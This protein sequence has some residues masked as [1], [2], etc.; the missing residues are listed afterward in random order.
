M[1]TIELDGATYVLVPK[2]AWAKLARG[3]VRMP[4]LPPADEAGN[5]D[6]IAFARVSIARTLI[7]DRVAAGLSQAELARRAGMA[8]ESLNRIERARVTPD[9]K[10]AARLESAIKQA[11]TLRPARRAPVS[12]RK[13]VR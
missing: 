3:E 1:K 4:E 7:R 8:R 5:R 11:T 10:T 2:E 6:A 9:E 12:R 13:A